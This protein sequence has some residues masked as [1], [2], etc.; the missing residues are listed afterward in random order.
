M[1]ALEKQVEE[2]R[3]GHSCEFILKIKPNRHSSE[4]DFIPPISE[5][6]RK[7]EHYQVDAYSLVHTLEITIRCPPDFPNVAPNV[8]ISGIPGIVHPNISKSGNMN[9][10]LLN[11]WRKTNTLMMIIE[12]VLELLKYPDLANVLNH[13]AAKLFRRDEAEYYRTCMAVVLAMDM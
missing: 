1:L 3:D 5:N 8:E 6:Y 9:F 13:D 10:G 4:N 2:V 12:E 11:N 7:K